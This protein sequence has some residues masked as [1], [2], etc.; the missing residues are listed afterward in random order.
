MGSV[1]VLKMG[2]G[3]DHAELAE[4][5][6]IHPFFVPNRAVAELKDTVPADVTTPVETSSSHICLP[7]SHEEE[8]D[9]P[10]DDSLEKKTGR[11]AKRRKS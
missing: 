3:V 7:E 8:E 11:K 2:A 5:K 10:E 9:G 1:V 4:Q 6:R